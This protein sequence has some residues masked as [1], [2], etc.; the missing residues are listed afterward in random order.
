MTEWIDAGHPFGGVSLAL[1]GEAWHGQS[2]EGDDVDPDDAVP[3]EVGIVF[4]ADE[5]VVLT[6]TAA[7]V[8]RRLERALELVRMHE[9]GAERADSAG[10]RS[11]S[12]AG[13][14]SFITG[15]VRLAG[16]G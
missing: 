5:S 13:L 2:E 6:G 4:S 15:P 14:Q 3:G 7:Q 1:R 9:A 11:S 16:Q 10:H 8:R 12:P